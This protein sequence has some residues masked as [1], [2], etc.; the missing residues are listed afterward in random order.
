[1]VEGGR[2]LEPKA[3]DRKRERGRAMM[4]M[5]A[6]MKVPDNVKNICIN[7]ATVT[8]VTLSDDDGCDDYD[9]T[10]DAN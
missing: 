3:V 1:M 4:M 6:A 2:G 7:N 5:I 10:H 9:V 8:M